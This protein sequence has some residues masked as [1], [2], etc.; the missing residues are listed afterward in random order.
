MFLFRLSC[1]PFGTNAILFGCDATKKAAVVDPAAGSAPVLLKKAEDKGFHIEKILLTHSH[2]DHI[3][4]L[5][6][7]K[8]ATQAPVYVH[9]LDAGNVQNPGSDQVPGLLPVRPVVPDVLLED[10]QT[11]TVGNLRIETIHTPGHAR[12]AVCFYLPEEGVLFSGDTVFRGSIGTLAL[13]T[14][15]PEKM[16]NSL[17][18][19]AKLPSHTRVIPG[20]GG[21]T[22][23]GKE[24]LGN[25]D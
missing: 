17:H 8:E 7:L 3:V 15:E 2:W 22:T 21:E 10:G 13:A 11:L 18:K 6:A 25:Y 12:G 5:A 4:D 1:P 14:S 19:L 23:I 9:R 16:T 24:S 20:H